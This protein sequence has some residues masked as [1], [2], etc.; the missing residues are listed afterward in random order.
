LKYDLCAGQRASIIKMGQ[1]IRAQT[2]PILYSINPGNGQNDLDPPKQNWDMAGVANVWRIGF[3]I[4]ASWSSVMRLLDENSKLYSYAGPGGFNDPD[5]LEV[6]KLANINEDRSHFALWAL[7]AAP[8]IAGNDIRNMS[9]NTKAILTNSEIIAVNQD[10]LGIQG[11]VVA[12]PGQDLQVWSKTLSGNNKRAVVLFNRSNNTASI[13]VK[14]SDL[15]LP[16]GAATVRDLWSHTDLGRFS[17]SYTATNIPAHGSG[18]V[19]ISSAN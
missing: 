12:T 5:M 16:A 19:I 14:W 3:D 13:T 18:M 8:L 15:G 2:R 7:M 10:V 6:G 1:A 11:R 17:D 4:N 9:A